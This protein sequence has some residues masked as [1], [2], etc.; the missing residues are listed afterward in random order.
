MEQ[1]RLFENK[2]LQQIMVRMRRTQPL[3]YSSNQQNLVKTYLTIPLDVKTYVT[4][5]LDVKT[6]AQAAEA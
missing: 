6:L 2:N 1:N 4:I 3:I 5:P